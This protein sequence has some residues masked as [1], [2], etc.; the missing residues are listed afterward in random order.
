MSVVG[1]DVRRGSTPSKSE[2]LVRTVV[3]ET[4]RLLVAALGRCS[5]L[6]ASFDK[7]FAKAMVAIAGRA[8]GALTV[9]QRSRLNALVYRYRRQIAATIVAKAALRL[10]EEQAAFRLRQPPEWAAIAEPPAV[11]RNPLDDLFGGG[12]AS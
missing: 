3:D 12:G 10:A 1:I 5:F 11:R 9:R 6:P 8:D 4:D 2:A 7:R